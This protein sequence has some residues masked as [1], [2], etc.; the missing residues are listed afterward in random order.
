[1]IGHGLDVDVAVD[2]EMG[3]R[4]QHRILDAGEPDRLAVSRADAL[5]MSRKAE[6]RMDEMAELPVAAPLPTARAA[7]W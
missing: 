6:Q 4:D 2:R 3:D 5:M 7:R 1:V